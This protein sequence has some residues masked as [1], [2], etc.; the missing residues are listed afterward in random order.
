[1]SIKFFKLGFI[2]TKDEN[3]HVCMLNKTKKCA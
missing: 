2:N 3:E 1:M